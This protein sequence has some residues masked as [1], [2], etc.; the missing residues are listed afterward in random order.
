MDMQYHTASMIPKGDV[1][2]FREIT[3]EVVND[4]IRLFCWICL[5]RAEGSE[6]REDDGVYCPSIIE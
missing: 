2:V 5:G 4:G 1:G 3:E 6:A